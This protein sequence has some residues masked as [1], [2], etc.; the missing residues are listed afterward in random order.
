MAYTTIPPDRAFHRLDVSVD[1]ENSEVVPAVR[2]VRAEAR[3]SRSPAPDGRW[4]DRSTE[5]TAA[6]LGHSFP[7]KRVRFV[8][9]FRVTEYSRAAPSR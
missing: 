3:N 9:R 7:F 8:C 5:V 6:M 1:Y 2:D 4:K